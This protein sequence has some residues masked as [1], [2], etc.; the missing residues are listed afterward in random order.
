MAKDISPSYEDLQTYYA[1]EPPPNLHPHPSFPGMHRGEAVPKGMRIWDD[2]RAGCTEKNG[3]GWIAS[4]SRKGEPKREKWFN[5]RTTGSWRLSFL[6]ARLQLEIWDRR[7]GPGYNEG[8][9]AS[10]EAPADARV[11]GEDA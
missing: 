10:L 1:G 4:R 6:L 2:L 5:I 8:K 7:G 9:S 3:A 11:A